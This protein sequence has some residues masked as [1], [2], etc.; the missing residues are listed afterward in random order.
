MYKAPSWGWAPGPRHCSQPSPPC[1]LV[2]SVWSAKQ[3]SIGINKPMAPSLW[4][5][6]CLQPRPEAETSPP[7]YCR[8]EDEAPA[9][10]TQGLMGGGEAD[11]TNRESSVSSR[12]PACSARFPPTPTPPGSAR[13][14][15][16]SWSTIGEGTEWPSA[17]T[18]LPTPLSPKQ[19]ERRRR[20][21]GEL[22]GVTASGRQLA[23]ASREGAK[24]RQ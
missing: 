18:S 1:P 14:R 2:P 15:E 21:R 20:K 22:S 8:L 4:S 24:G 6:G 16:G 11:K 7:Y 19:V 12:Q 13:W 3:I 10:G 5:R 17:S 23:P 9:T